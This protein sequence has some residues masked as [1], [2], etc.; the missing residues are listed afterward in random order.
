MDKHGVVAN[1]RA[2]W[3]KADEIAGP[4]IGGK[5]DYDAA[6]TVADGAVEAEEVGVAGQG[7]PAAGP[8]L[9]AKA[10]HVLADHRVTV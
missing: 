8:K 10:I 2:L 1:H 9:V 3:G 6:L 4:L 7:E 5:I